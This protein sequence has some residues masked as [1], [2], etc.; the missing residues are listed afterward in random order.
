VAGSPTLTTTAT[1]TSS[2]ASSP[3]TITVVDAG[4]LSAPNYDFP[5]AN[6]VNG[7]LT[8]TPAPLTV[9]AKNQTKAYASTFTFTG[10]E[11][12]ISGTLFNGDTVT[13]VTL[14]SAGAAGTATVAG[15]PYAITP[16]AA[17]GT[18]VANYSITYAN[19]SLTVTPIPLTVTANSTSKSYGATVTFAGTEF[20]VTSGTLFNGDTVTSVTLTSAGAA[21]AATVAG[22][23]YTITPSVAVGP[24]VSNYTITYSPGLLQVN[25]E[26]LTITANNQNKTYGQ[27]VTFAGTEFTPTGLQNTDSVTNVTLT[28]T[29]TPANATVQGGP[30]TITASAAV[31]T[32]LSN[33]NIAYSPGILTVTG[34]NLTIT[35]NST[36]KAYGTTL[37]FAGTEFNAN[38]LVNNGN[39]DSVTSVSLNS[40]GAAASATVTGGPYSIVPSS[41]VGSGLSNYSITLVNGQLTV[42]PV[43]LTITANNRAKT[44]G[45]AVTF[46]G[47]EF[48]PSG[49][50]NGDTVTSVSLTSPGAIASATVAGGPYS[51]VASSPIG[52][53]LS[54]YNPSFVSGTLTV[55]PATLMVTANNTSKTYGQTVTFT[56]AEFTTNGLQNGD[57]VTSVSLISAGAPAT[58]SVAG[59]PYMITPSAAVGT[60]LANYTITYPTGTLAVNSASLM[61]TPNVATKTYGATVTFTGTEFTS[62]GLLN[63]DA[64]SKAML[65]SSGTPG[66]ATVV[67]SPYT[68]DASAAVGSG[69]SNYNI[70]YAT[71]AL[72]VTPAPLAITANNGSKIYGQAVTFAGTE[73]TTSGLLNADTVVSIA[74]AS[75]GAVATANVGSYSIVPS[76]PSGNGLSN[77]AVSF[78]N[79]ALAVT[80]ATTTSTVVV[81]VGTNAA[82]Y[83]FNATVSP[84]FSGAPTGTVTFMDNGT[85]L[86]AGA[87]GSSTV[88]L[89]NGTASF[90]LNLNQLAA[91]THK[92]T[93]LYNKDANFAGAAT[94]IAASI[95]VNAT[96]SVS[97]GAPIPSQTITL[98][99][100]TAQDI[101]YNNMK[102]SVLSSLGQPVA[103]TLCSPSTT[104]LTVPHGGTASFTV[105]LATNSASAQPAQQQAML[106]MRA[107]N[108]LWLAMP[109]VFFLPFAAPVRTRRKLFRRKMITWLGVVVLLVFLMMSMGCGGGGFKN[110]NNSQ[111][112]SGT[113]T[114]TQP[115]SYIVQVFGTGPSGQ[116]S[117]ASVPFTVGF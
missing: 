45:Q 40:L 64:V 79:G 80:P 46:T 12:T 87:S 92:I 2:V 39:G 86:G 100:P 93:A 28:S 110:P 43:T 71:N 52:S 96:L 107:L 61:I 104:S 33:Y 32:G 14:S 115:G 21:G 37:T 95:T 106:H 15:S 31:G 70:S 76:S 116:T 65:T 38:G 81:P 9:T 57:T 97:P 85:A 7:Q 91:G 67:G 94:A 113:N 30:Y 13:S 17:A 63:G 29:G 102:C 103:N 98:S 22:S 75:T 3:Y 84:Q 99:N 101:T 56:G 89:A 77:Y 11:F 6:F 109:A 78:N 54:N 4:N 50:L 105:Q 59:S 26:L 88:A 82:E 83:T 55:N 34:A 24:G 36:S 51:I 44:Y 10:T 72:F 90:T 8:I 42:T 27:A 48:T 47:T 74:L 111:P 66:T 114:T 25:K 18:G 20:A 62:S 112:G 69:L 1:A 108:G 49:L 117:L 16:S 68:I 58:A 19:G 35:A 73:F 23:P 60:G 53:G 5:A 41:P